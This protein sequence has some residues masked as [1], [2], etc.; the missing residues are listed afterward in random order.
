MAFNAYL[1]IDGI[2]GESIDKGHEGWIEIL[3]YSQSISQP[4]SAPTPSGGGGTGKPA[5]QDFVITKHVDIASPKL[6]EACATGKHFPNAVIEVTH[7]AKAPVKY[8]TI[9]MQQVF[10][11]SINVPSPSAADTPV[12]TVSLS[13]AAIQWAYTPQNPDGSLGADVTGTWTSA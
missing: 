7:A 13:Y 5:H 1:Q 6:Y 9:D 2:K 10:I 11:S 12:E 4:I 3:S 8:I